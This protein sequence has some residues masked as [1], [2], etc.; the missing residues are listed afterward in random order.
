M[1][2]LLSIR[3]PLI[4]TMRVVLTVQHHLQRNI[5]G[6]QL[7]RGLT[8]FHP[9][10]GKSALVA[11]AFDETIDG[12]I[13][14]QSG[15][16]GASLSKDKKGETVAAITEGYQHWFAPAYREENLTI[17]QHQLLALIAPRPVLLGN[18]SAM[19]NAMFG[20]TQKEPFAR[21]KVQ[22]RC[23][24]QLSYGSSK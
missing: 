16:G 23:S 6:E 8:S 22:G 13:A 19:P 24:I 7:A 3:Q 12:V 1:P 10:Q 20:P 2:W 5:R 14:H 17:D 4:L 21:P 11:A 15:T 9:F 18:D